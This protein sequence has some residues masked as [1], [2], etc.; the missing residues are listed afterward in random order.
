MRRNSLAYVCLPLAVLAACGQGTVTQAPDPTE[1]DSTTTSTL[2]ASVNQLPTSTAIA[3]PAF[4][5]YSITTTVAPSP[6]GSATA[7][8]VT[9]F[10]R[11]GPGDFYVRVEA[12]G[13]TS[14]Q[15]IV[16]E[17]WSDWGLGYSI[18]A[19][20]GWSP[21]SRRVYIAD[22]VVPDG[23]APF[24]LLMHVRHVSIPYGSP[25]AIEFDPSGPL[26]LSPNADEIGTIEGSHL[27][28]YSLSGERID[29]TELSLA[30]ADRA[31]AI[32]WVQSGNKLAFV[33]HR[34]ACNGEVTSDILVVDREGMRVES[35]LSVPGQRVWTKRWLGDRMIL[36][37]SQ[38]GD[39][40]VLDTMTGQ[41]FGD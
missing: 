13:P 14:P 27:A 9:A 19:I 40:M 30:E 21:D 5:R 8:V 26:S 20:L 32:V 2:A 17:E 1:V 3:R 25:E 12:N 15:H 34:N 41:V 29:A 6:D 37:Q 22:K 31:G 7:V 23:C 39:E 35:I 28:M 33:I 36:L 18:P 16:L 38:G 4:S 24:D 10:P 11:S